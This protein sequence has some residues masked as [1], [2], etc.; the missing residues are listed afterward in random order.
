MMRTL[1]YL[2]LPGTLAAQA[3]ILFGPV[4]ASPAPPACSSVPFNFTQ[5][6]SAPYTVYCYNRTGHTTISGGYVNNTGNGSCPGGINNYCKATAYGG[7]SQAPY[8]WP[9][10]GG[11]GSYGNNWTVYLQADSVVLA[12][13]SPNFTCGTDSITPGPPVT[14]KVPYCYQPPPP[15]SPIVID[16][17]GEG[18]WLTDAQHGVAFHEEADGSLQQMSWT[19]PAHHNAWLVRPN[20]DG[21]M[22][23]LAENMFGNLSPQPTSVHPNGY[24]ALAYLMEQEGCGNK[25]T[26]LDSN[27]GPVV[28][29]EL[30]LWQDGNQDGVAQ[31][32]ELH[33]LTDLG[34]YAI[35]LQFHESDHTDQYGNGF[36]YVRTSGTRRESKRITAA[37][38]CSFWCS[39]PFV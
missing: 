5:N 35:S 34:V 6:G 1:L 7:V 21:S 18:F 38:M 23:S 25:F 4:T 16:T 29:N 22:T 26:R 37:M 31:S 19:D 12:G 27:N 39:K 13:A 36:R 9:T 24:A 11:A 15:P 2:L 28:W 8:F 30:R 10:G 33:T 32:E 3:Y 17:T 20:P 14:V